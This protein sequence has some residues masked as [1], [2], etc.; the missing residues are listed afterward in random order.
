MH[1]LVIPSEFFEHKEIPL[2]GIFQKDSIKVLV[3]N[4]CQVGVLAVKPEYTTYDLIYS[5]VKTR[6]RYF[7]QAIFIQ[8]MVPVCIKLTNSY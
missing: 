8:V 1:I 7:K 6:I 5:T 4:N 2:A 3:K